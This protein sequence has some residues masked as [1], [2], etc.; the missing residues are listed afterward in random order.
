MLTPP[1]AIA[2][3]ATPTGGEL[4]KFLIK[5]RRKIGV[6]PPRNRGRIRFVYH[7]RKSAMPA[8]SLAFFAIAVYKPYSC[9]SQHWV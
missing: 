5:P 9:S 3:Q 6:L 1:A 7:C 4:Q 8:A 2:G